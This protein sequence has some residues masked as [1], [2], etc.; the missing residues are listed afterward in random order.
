MLGITPDK[1]KI[2][3][4]T[5]SYPSDEQD[6]SGIF[7][8][9]LLKAIKE[10]GHL[11]KVVAPSNG[12]SYGRGMLEGVETVRFGYFIPRS[13]E[14]LT[15]GMGGIPESMANSR[16]ARFQLAPMMARF[17]GSALSESKSADLIYAN[18]LGAG[19]VGAALKAITGKPLVVS[20][21][22]DD[23]Y[24]ARDRSLWRVLTSWVIRQSD[25]VAP[26]S[27]ELRDILVSLGA[28]EDRCQVPRFGVD[29]ET[30]RPESRE[31]TE[32]VE[33]I[34]VGALIRKKGVHDLL[35]ALAGAG[36]ANTRLVL[37]GD[38][39]DAADLMSLSERLGLKDRVEW[40]GVQPPDEVARLMR[41][42]DFLCLPSYTEG[43]PNVIIEAMA[44]GLPVVATRIGGIPDMVKEPEMALLHAPGDV[45]GLR[46]CIDRLVEKPALRAEMGRK[47]RESVM[48]SGLNWDTTALDFEN[49][50]A[51]AVGSR[52]E[53]AEPSR[54]SLGWGHDVPAQ[55]PTDDG[56]VPVA[57][58]HGRLKPVVLN[59]AAFL[60]PC[61]ISL[62][63]FLILLNNSPHVKLIL[64]AIGAANLAGVFYLSQ[65]RRKVAVVSAM[66][67]GSWGSA[68][69]LGCL[70]ATEGLFPT[71][72]PTQYAAV[73]GLDR[74]LTPF[75]AEPRSLHNLLSGNHRHEASSPSP[76]FVPASGVIPPAMAPREIAPELSSSSD[77]PDAGV[78]YATAFHGDLRESYATTRGGLAGPGVGRMVFVR[79]IFVE[80]EG[81]PLAETF[82]PIPE[83]SLNPWFPQQRVNRF[84]FVA[85]GNS[86]GG[87]PINQDTLKNERLAFAASP[88]I[89]ARGKPGWEV[90]DNR[91]RSND[92]QGV[93]NSLAYLINSLA[94]QEG[95]G[96]VAVSGHMQQGAV[97]SPFVPSLSD[98]FEFMPA[99]TPARRTSADK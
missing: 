96:G 82:H 3:V 91:F 69:V 88:L 15:T 59:A 13:M 1:F 52:E 55:A 92:R 14:K 60:A 2:L 81:T 98:Y 76:V 11:V 48:Q 86:G 22:G 50:F 94:V 10:R 9:K 34:Y 31:L 20:F 45:A 78:R 99:G 36:H 5:T 23:G 44:S 4:L 27:R 33:I 71:Y 62:S 67:L 19:I 87:Q 63:L 74:S 77:D 95:V 68:V 38:G 57:L 72:S 97:C 18:W 26:V 75:P 28:P 39:A 65:F 70:L 17:F 58:T 85:F 73:Q 7:I 29:V 79:G 90:S 21:R 43:R 37:V 54:R 47:A 93:S 53:T 64:A 56:F 12:R 32:G 83:P 24:L 61:L 84:V 25:Q 40:K 6:P 16:L 51:Q 42:A 30:F 41:R 80:S 46:E 66:K 89:S 49:I 8:A 35:A